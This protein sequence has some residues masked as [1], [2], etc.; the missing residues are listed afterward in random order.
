MQTRFSAIF[1]GL[2][3]LVACSAPPSGEPNDATES[4]YT[5][6]PTGSTGQLRVSVP[7]AATTTHVMARRTDGAATLFEL[8]PGI[9]KSVS[10]GTYCIYTRVTSSNVYDVL[11]ET[12][13]DCAVAVKA[14]ATVDYALGAVKFERSRDESIA[15]LDV[16]FDQSY[17]SRAARSMLTS[18]ATIA[19]VPGSFSYPYV[20]LRAPYTTTY[21][22]L[23]AIGFSIAGGTTTSVDLV[24]TTAKWAV[25]VIPGSPRALPN[26]TAQVS[27]RMMTADG[28]FLDTW[29]NV[30]A[31]TKPMLVRALASANLTVS[32]PAAQVVALTQPMTDRKLARLDVESVQVDM[33]GGIVKTATG[34]VTI[35]AL[36][37]PTGTGIDL[38]PGHYDLSIA[39]SHPAD[40]AAIVTSAS[41]DLTP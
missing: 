1:F 33:P 38:L 21:R 2:S 25:R 32:I 30:G 31:L 16:G 20:S 34:T 15:G 23:D 7:A 26:T 3:A 18:A 12:Q 35:G 4:D 22:T 10:P 9:A 27:A 8:A 6:T 37:F 29:L 11:F 41:I 36:A 24:D 13:P 40:N 14:G 17:A 39:Y 19:H 28:Y 5:V